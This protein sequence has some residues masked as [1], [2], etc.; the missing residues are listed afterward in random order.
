MHRRDFLQNIVRTGMLTG[1][2]LS[3]LP[4]LALNTSRTRRFL[5]VFCDGAWDTSMVFCS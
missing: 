2:G 4:S 3:M 5:F 1:A